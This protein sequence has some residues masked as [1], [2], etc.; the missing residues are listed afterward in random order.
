MEAAATNPLPAQ[1]KTVVRS[2]LL[3]DKTGRAQ[4][5]VSKHSL[6][7]LKSTKDQTES[8][9][10][11]V[12]PAKLEA[13]YDS[14]RLTQLSNIPELNN[15]TTLSDQSIAAYKLIIISSSDNPETKPLELTVLQK[16]FTGF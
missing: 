12:S 15:V 3:Q 2:I 1:K 13:F 10:V 7:D 11:A 9:L 4:A 5:I 8:D 16:G 6:L 14:E